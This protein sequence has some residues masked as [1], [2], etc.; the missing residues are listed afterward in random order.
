MSTYLVTWNPNRW[1]WDMHENIAALKQ[2]GF[3]D[4]RWS[5][6]RTKSIKTGD[7][8]FLLRQGREPRGILA[9]GVAKSEPYLDEHWDDNRSG[10]AL[11]VKARFDSLLDPE[12][13]GVLPLSRLQDGPLGAVNWRTQ[14]SGISIS[15]PAAAE[16]EKRWRAFL[17]ERGQ[18]P[19]VMPDEVSTPSLYY[20]GVSRTVA[21]NAYERD[22]RARKACIDHYGATC[23]VCGF[24]FGAVYG[25]LGQGFIHVH[26]IV[27]LSKIGKSYVVNPAKDLRPVCPNCHAM[28][29][30]GPEVLSVEQL[31]AILSKDSSNTRIHAHARKSGARG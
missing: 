3:F 31:K 2:R 8:L 25:D 30:R 7:R 17:E 29:H 20:E 12:K 18:S 4:S 14:S 15:P 16:L 11:Y 21:V 22:P 24:D 19:A 26:H 1:E 28:L 6:G 27:P 23:F 10:E 5:C 9:A 13:D